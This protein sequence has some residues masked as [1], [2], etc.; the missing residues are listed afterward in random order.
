[1]LLPVIPDIS[2]GGSWTVD[3]DLGIC[4]GRIALAIKSNNTDESTEARCLEIDE[5]NENNQWGRSG[6][7]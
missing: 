1:M 6:E 5:V 7:V 4:L 3:H 2:E